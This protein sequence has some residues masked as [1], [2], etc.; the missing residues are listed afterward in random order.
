MAG[1]VLFLDLGGLYKGDNLIVSSLSYTFF[2][3]NFLSS[4]Y[5]TVKKVKKDFEII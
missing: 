5:F 2:D 4:F 3:V 1:K